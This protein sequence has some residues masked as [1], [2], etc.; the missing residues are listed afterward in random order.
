[1]LDDGYLY[2]CLADPETGALVFARTLEEHQK[3]VETYSPLWET[4][5]ED[6]E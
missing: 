2:F 6:A 4:G 3:N 5:G 1:M